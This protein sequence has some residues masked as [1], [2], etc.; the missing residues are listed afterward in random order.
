CST[1]NIKESLSKDESCVSVMSEPPRQDDVGIEVEGPKNLGACFAE[2]AQICGRGDTVEALSHLLA[3]QGRTAALSSCQRA[4]TAVGPGATILCGEFANAN[5]A[6]PLQP[7]TGGD[8]G[9]I[10]GA[11]QSR[12]GFDSAVSTTGT[13]P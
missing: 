1:Q 4:I 12:D 5:A 10:R 2:L 3:E 9:K 7:L 11:I 8:L 13:Y 6:S